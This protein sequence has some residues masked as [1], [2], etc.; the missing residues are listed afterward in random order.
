M[1]EEAVV[2]ADL[3]VAGVLLGD[4]MDGALDLAAVRGVAAAGSGIVGAGDF[5]DV[6]RSVLLAAGAGHEVAPA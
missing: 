1:R 2:E 5:D 4:P 3:D 6:A